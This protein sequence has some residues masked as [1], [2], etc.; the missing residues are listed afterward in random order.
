MLLQPI[1]LLDSFLHF[2]FSL[3]IPFVFLFRFSKTK[4]R[5]CRKPLIYQG[6]S[7]FNLVSLA[8]FEPTAFRLGGERSIQLSYKDLYKIWTHLP[9]KNIPI[10]YTQQNA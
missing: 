6:F 10:Y 2:C 7:A 1:R 9:I 8:G 3:L 5:K 4:K